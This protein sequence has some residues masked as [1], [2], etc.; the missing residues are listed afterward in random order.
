MTKTKTH[1]VGCLFFSALCIL[2]LTVNAQT[3]QAQLRR[4]GRSPVAR[5]NN[6]PAKAAAVYGAT[7]SPA[8]R[9]ANQAV[10]QSNQNNRQ[11]NWNNKNENQKVATYNAAK[12]HNTNKKNTQAAK[13]SAVTSRASSASA[14]RR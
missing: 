11:D 12:I 7:T 4:V 13:Q 8:E 3:A 1:S 9:Y 2:G 10:H 14:R 6:D 5:Y